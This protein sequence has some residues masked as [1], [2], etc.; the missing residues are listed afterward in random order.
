MSNS[1]LVDL[2]SYSPNHSGRRKNPITKIAIHHTA[3]VLTAAGI[4]NVFKSRSR[5]ASCNYGIGNDNKVVLVVDECNRAWTTS[6]A[7]CDNRAVTI[8]VSNCQYGGNWI[9]SDRVLNT[10]IDLVTDICRR[11]KIKN[12]TYT[13]GKDGV[14]QMHKWYAQ[15]S[16]PGP[17]LASKFTYIAQEVNKRLRGEKNTSSSSN[18]YR[19]RKSWEDSKSQK[20]AFKNLNSAI[21]LAKKNGYKV[22]DSNGNQVYPEV[23]QANTSSSAN[24]NSTSPKFIKY[25]NWTGV[26]QAVCNVRSAPNTRAEIVATYGVGQSIKY[27]Q[28]WEGD[29]YRWISYIGASGKR[30]YVACRKLYGDT[31]PW[32]RF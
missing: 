2:V 8:E 5:K 28:V 11:N 9:V 3:G 30:R 19:V 25:E 10:L 18:L 24:T 14:L 13:G 1:N 32:I 12:C 23:K 6:S 29:G 16:C 27:D 21:D 4:G 15:T 22:Y 26:T 31:R 20:G 7:W 17:Y